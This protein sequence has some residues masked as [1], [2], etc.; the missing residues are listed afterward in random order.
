M[1]GV[2]IGLRS[3]M[4]WTL[5]FFCWNLEVGNGGRFIRGAKKKGLELEFHVFFFLIHVRRLPIG[6]RV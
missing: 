3:E 2:E 6:T 5:D 1:S 4:Q